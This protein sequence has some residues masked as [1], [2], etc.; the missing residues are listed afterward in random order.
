MKTHIKSSTQRTEESGDEFSTSVG[1]YVF[2][3]SMFGEYML[4]KEDSEVCG[5][6]FVCGGYEDSLFGEAVDY[7]EDG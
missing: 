3:Y 6:Y 2:G 1:C 4:D 7:H 5:G